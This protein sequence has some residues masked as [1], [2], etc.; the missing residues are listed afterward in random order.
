M[1]SRGLNL[2]GIQMAYASSAQ[3]ASTSIAQ[4]K[5]DVQVVTTTMESG[6]YTPLI[7]QKG[8][9]VKWTIQAT[10]RDLNGCNNP[11]TI[12]EYGIE[13]TL[14]P[15]DNVI[16]FTPQEEGPIV[17]TCWMGMISSTINVVPDVASASED[18]IAP[19]GSSGGFNGGGCCRVN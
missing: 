18:D 3:T 4:V 1:L 11:V 10:A 12:P 7:V 13:K 15:G 9:P 19:A 16:E 6:R 14:Q 17:Y 2:S 8:V 5:G